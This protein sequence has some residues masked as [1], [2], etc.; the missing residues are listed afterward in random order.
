M[1]RP[2]ALSWTVPPL[3]LAAPAIAAAWALAFEVSRLIGL[4]AKDYTANDFRLFYVAAQVGVRWGWSTI[5]DPGRQQLMSEALGPGH[6]AIIA[7]YTYNFPPLVAWIA[8]LLLFLP[9]PA[10]FYAWG[11]LNVGALVAA[12]RFAF[13]GETFKWLTALLIS[14]AVWPTA[15]SLERGQPALLVFA[16]AITCWWLAAKGRE[17]WAGAALGVAWAI[18]P[19]VVLLLPAVLLLCGFP[20]AFAWWLLTTA[21]AWTL[22]ALVIG[23]TGLGTYLAVLSWESSDP[24]FATTPLVA[25]FGRGTSLLLGQA[26]FAGVTL[27]AVWRQR[28]SLRIAFAIGIAGTLLSAVHLHV[29]DYVGL[30]VAAWLVLGRETVSVIDIAWIA[31]GV[32][33]V[34]L[35]AIGLGWPILVWQPIWLVLLWIRPR[36]GRPVRKSRPAV[37]DVRISGRI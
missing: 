30:V 25:P 17:R 2:A 23:P 28:R 22:F 14:L 31:V 24:G 7:L 27:A 36:A 37:A 15:F 21:A 32:V 6:P 5:Y 35:S 33:C 1:S 11:G 3:R 18:K 9:L 19:Q 8:A 29:Y 13:P 26:L 4:V 34:Q 10:A 16:L 20:R 12:S